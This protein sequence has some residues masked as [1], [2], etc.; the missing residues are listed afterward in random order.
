MDVRIFY[1]TEEMLKN[2]QRDWKIEELAELSHLSVSHLQKLF[3]SE[4]GTSPIAYL[5]DLRLE[6]ARALLEKEDKYLNINEVG[7]LVGMPND[8]HFTR[9]FKKKFGATPSEYRKRY[10]NNVIAERLN[11]RK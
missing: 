11:G 9:D 6:K 7:R 4:I 1:L 2:L 5:R 3:K 8:S 10:W